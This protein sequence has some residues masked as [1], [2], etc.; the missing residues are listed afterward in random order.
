MTGNKT[1]FYGNSKLM[2]FG[3]ESQGFKIK[4]NDNDITMNMF[5]VT[6]GTYN[7]FEEIY[8]FAH[9]T[10]NTAQGCASNLKEQL[11]EDKYIK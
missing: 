9:R 11:D 4:K 5:G 2:S 6:L 10:L 7:K 8:K 3:F 1:D